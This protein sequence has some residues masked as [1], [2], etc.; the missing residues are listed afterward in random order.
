MRGIDFAVFTDHRPLLGVFK[1]ALTDI[2]NN[3]LL[4]FREKLTDFSFVLEYVPGKTHLIADALSR[5]PVFSPP[6][7]EMISANI[8]MVNKLAADPALQHFYDAAAS[9]PFYS[10]IVT[11]L[12]AGKSPAVLPPSHP[13]RTL[14][15]IWTDL[16]VLDDVLLILSDSRLVVPA[17]C[18]DKVLENLHASH[19]GI[20]K[21][22][23]L[24]RNLYYWPGMSTAIQSMIESCE[25][26]QP[27]RP[28]L[29]DDTLFHPPAEI[30]MHSVSCDLFACKGR[31]FL[32]MVD[33]YSYYI[34][35]KELKRLGTDA[36]TTA[37]DAWFKDLGYPFI[38]V[39]DNG[40]QF[41]EDFKQYC[42]ENFIIHSPS[43]A[44]N[45]RSNGLAESAVKAAKHLLLKSS[46]FSEFEQ[47]LF[48]WRNTPTSGSTFS[49]AE[50]FYNRRQRSALLP[51]LPS[52]ALPAPPA[53]PLTSRLPVLHVGDPVLLQN[54][55]TK[56][57]DTSGVVEAINPSTL[58]YV[59]RRGD[60]SIASRGRRLLRPDKVTAPPVDTPP[61]REI[62]PPVS[63]TPDAANSADN[64][65]APPAR[66]QSPVTPADPPLRRSR[67]HR[68]PPTRLAYHRK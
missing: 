24:A 41:R 15:G 44:Y 38:L 45:P 64:D 53:V 37:L 55:L 48:A 9:D 20:S 10:E 7:E 8:A 56:R 32:A 50:K 40:P 14:K 49:P 34:W 59:V 21:T 47:S 12:L 1:K 11:A 58:S 66:A 18:R 35:V 4:R 22:R 61:E 6:E 27:L 30:P 2:E 25:D 63:P 28:S 23:Q 3:R 52:L 68:R 19:S 39:S 17:A 57:W 54:P 42:R 33:R 16:S 62:S 31:D 46:S 51:S 67:R 13:A 36:V 43:S 26:C 60:G 65:D 29:H 5:A